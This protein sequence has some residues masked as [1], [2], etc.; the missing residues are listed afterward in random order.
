MV[1]LKDGQQTGDGGQ[2]T[3]SLMPHIAGMHICIF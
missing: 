3:M 1:E 2:A